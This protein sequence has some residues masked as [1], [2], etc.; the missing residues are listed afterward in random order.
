[1]QVFFDATDSRLNISYVGQPQQQWSKHRSI[2]CG[3]SIAYVVPTVVGEKKLQ[4]KQRG[5]RRAFLAP[6]GRRIQT[7]YV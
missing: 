1:M 7:E 5:V 4:L 2:L 6:A 3:K